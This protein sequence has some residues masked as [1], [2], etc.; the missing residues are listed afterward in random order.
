MPSH[1]SRAP[2]ALLLS[3]FDEVCLTYRDTG[4]PRRDPSVS[5]ARLVSEA[6][7]GIVVVNDADV[8]VWKRTVTPTAVK[9]SVWGDTALDAADTAALGD[10]A[11]GLAAFLELPLELTFA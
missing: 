10:T 7:G 9:V 2:R 4:F 5:R 3:T 8:G 1:T 11:S 6:G